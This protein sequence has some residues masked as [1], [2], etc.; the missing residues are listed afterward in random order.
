MNGSRSPELATLDGPR[1]RP[2]LPLL[3][4]AV[5]VAGCGDAAESRGEVGVADAVVPDALLRDR[6]GSEWPGRRDAG[7][8]DAGSPDAGGD[9]S[10]CP[11]GDTCVGERS[12]LD[13]G[14]CV[15][16]AFGCWCRSGEWWCETPRAGTAVARCSD[17]S[18]MSCPGLPPACDRGRELAVRAG[19]W[20]CVEE[21]TCEPRLPLVQFVAP[22]GDR[23]E[24]DPLAGEC[25]EFQVEVSV[26]P[27]EGD[28]VWLRLGEPRPPGAAFIRDF[29]EHRA[30]FSWCPEPDVLPWTVQFVAQGPCG[31]FA[32]KA[33]EIAMRPVE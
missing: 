6:G 21:T 22:V 8:P 20:A 18:E 23:L 19:C 29:E 27:P 9:E 28:P 14:E 15:V 26:V 4:F 31:H 32:T 25:A 3:F 30:R 7:S 10:C 33:F 5:V 11:L 24:I 16:I 1:V 12:V 13:Y 2:W 17:G